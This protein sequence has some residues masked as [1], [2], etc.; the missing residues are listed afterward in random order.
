M[1]DKEAKR[2]TKAT[3]AAAAT[4]PTGRTRAEVQTTWEVLAANS[5]NVANSPPCFSFDAI[6]KIIY[7][8]QYELMN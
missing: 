6:F 2:T 5:E 4:A 7:E 8:K 3:T 1:T